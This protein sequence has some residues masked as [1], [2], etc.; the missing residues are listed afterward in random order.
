MRLPQNREQR[1]NYST[2]VGQL[3]AS[4]SDKYWKVIQPAL[5]APKRYRKNKS[6]DSTSALYTSQQFVCARDVTIAV[7][8]TNVEK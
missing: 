4:I 3:V 6:T 7:S 5:S 1:G 8:A 2:L